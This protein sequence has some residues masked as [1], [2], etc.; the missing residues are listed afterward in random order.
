MPDNQRSVRLLLDF[1]Q[2]ISWPDTKRVTTKALSFFDTHLKLERV[3]ITFND[4]QN[5]SLEVFT[6]DTSIPHLASGDKH[7]IS[8]PPGQKSG[9]PMEPRYTPDLSSI[10][11]PITVVKALSSAGIQ[12]FFDVPLLIGDDVVGS[13]NIGSRHQDGV[14]RETQEIVTLLSARLSLALFHARLHDDLKQKE[15]A[16]EAS[17]RGHRELIDQAAD[18]I[19][20]CN[21]QGDIIQ[22]NL[23][24]T[25]LLGYSNEDLL[26]M[27]LSELFEPDVL[28]RKPLR[29]DLVNE[30]LTVLSERA[31]RTKDGKQIP[32]EM[33]S[34]KLSDGTL[35]SI[36]RDLSERNKTKERLLD[37]KNQIIAL[38]DATPTLMYAKDPDG[39]YTML[40]DAYLKFFGKERKE[41]LGK[42]VTEI[43][44]TPS[45]RRVEKEDLKLLQDNELHSY[46]TEFKNASGVTRQMLAR[47][48]LYLDAQGNPAG[49][50]GTLMDY[51]DLK[52]AKNRY[53]TLFNNSPDPI[54]VHDGKVILTANR[55][56][57]DFFKA[58][59]PDKYVK[60]PVSA[61]VHPDSLRDSSKRI[62]AL[63][64]SKQPNN[65]VSQKFIIATG[66]VRDVEVMSVPIEDQGRIVIMSSFRDVTDE[67]IT[68]AALLN[69]EDR[70][71]LAFN[72]SPTAM[73]LH[74]QG[75]LLDANQAALDFAGAKNLEEVLGMDLFGLVHPDFL[76][77]ARGGIELLLKTGKPVPGVREQKYLTLSGEER[78]VEVKGVPVNQINK[79]VI[80]LSFNDISERV[81]AR[82]ELEKSRQQ[83]EIIT[84]HLTS[85]LFLIDLD[86]SLLYVNLSTAKLLEAKSEDVLGEPL[87]N[88]VPEEA[89]TAGLE[90]LPRLLK[91]EVCSFQY[92][93][94]SKSRG[95]FVFVLTLIPIKAEDG[96]VMAILVQ[97]D[98]VTEIASAR[99]EIAENKELLELIVDTIPGLFCYSDMNEK[100]LYVNEA[101]AN[102]YGYKKADVIGKSFNQII[103]EDTYSEIQ[104]Y[105]ARIATGEALS[106]SRTTTGPD[107]RAH[108][109]DLRYIPHFDTNKQPKAFLTSLQD[110]T[111]KREEEVFRDSLRRLA[112]QLTISLKPRQAGIIA[113]KLL[114][115]LFGYDAFALY[116]IILEKNEAVG[117]FSQDTFSGQDKPVKVETDVYIMDVENI[118]NT[119]ILPSPVLINR[120]ESSKELPLSPFGDASRLSLSLVFVPIFWEGVQIG[121]FTLQ[122]YT[123]EHF[124]EDDLQKLK[125]FANQI[126]GALVRAQA[127]ELILEQTSKLKDRELQLQSSIEEKEVLL[128]EIYHRTKNNMQ[129]IVGLLEMQGMKTTSAEAQTVVDEMTNRIYSMSMV[130][131]LLYRSR[132]LADIMLDTYLQELV[133][134]LI[135]AFKTTLGEI[136]LECSSESIPINIQTAIPLGLVINE[137]ISNA[138]KYAFPDHR[139]GKIIVL[140]K[141]LGEDGLAI[142]IGDNGV[143]LNRG[144]EL[145][146]AETLGLQIIR[147]IVD[148]Q[149]FG[150]LKTSSKGGVKYFITIPSLK[151]D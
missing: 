58:E 147:D 25:R 115:D 114:Y 20:K 111:E 22:A 15:A 106:Y 30:G 102:W 7:P 70:Y 100:Y 92:H 123:A 3:S 69:S 128:K 49:F 145:S 37:Q 34:K 46:A 91:G 51:T 65:I 13:L 150:K 4:I 130:H 132:S 125:I 90:Y 80:L 33:N 105:L 82:E 97:M 64:D 31:F 119:F 21:F 135:L 137:I 141:R 41:M 103:P 121:L 27:N 109:L 63:L 29:Y 48:A 1:D 118:E 133:N 117:L 126:G 74:D 96:E 61:F 107:G 9:T 62:K 26:Q 39:R 24:A 84:G 28:V 19:L 35:V 52:D 104:P 38:F 88:F 45:A 32:V 8:S 68:R 2:A 11:N 127:D 87:K 10:S 14:S 112:R 43:W 55:A 122:S 72:N 67:L 136:T 71:R 40:N 94:K 16:L 17:E 57:L 44:N 75:V 66:E 149:L 47:K 89:L 78:W 144:V 140:T 110:V 56:A 59:N 18:V 134:R 60:S 85:Y 23:A 108:D 146:S 76:K 99:E 36:V 95:A 79:T 151:L 143:G 5:Q 54:V 131:D 101:Y 6:K 12:S 42:R 139:D 142:E 98:D 138:L 120:K 81:T 113:A 77:A 73:V 50:V 86:L 129:V 53:Q 93:H 83:L 148:L 124:K 116:R